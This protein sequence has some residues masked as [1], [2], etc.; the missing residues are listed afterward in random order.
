MMGA[1]IL[2]TIDYAKRRPTPFPPLLIVL[3]EANNAGLLGKY[4]SHALAETRKYGL[5]FRIVVQSP[6][7]PPDIAENVFQNTGRKEYYRC[8]SYDVARKAALDIAAGMYFPSDSEI[9]RAEHVARLTTDLLNMPPGTRYVRDQFCS[10]R[11]YVPLLKAPW[12]FASLQAKKLREKLAR[13]YTKPQYA[14]RTAIRP[15]SNWLPTIPPRPNN[16][17]APSSPAQRWKQRGRRPAD[18]SIGF[19]ENG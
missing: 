6:T 11:E 15:S 10:R 4:E 19:A 18:D 12:T 2:K 14:G 17:P 13:I 16:L 9:S 5:F 8:G 1:I 7:F 3:E